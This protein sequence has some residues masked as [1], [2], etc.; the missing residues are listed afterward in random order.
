LDCYQLVKES[1][2]GAITVFVLRCV[3]CDRSFGGLLAY[4]GYLH[5]PLVPVWSNRTGGQV[6]ALQEPS[7]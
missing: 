1:G 6:G 3:H 7:V 5:Y 2:H 4:L